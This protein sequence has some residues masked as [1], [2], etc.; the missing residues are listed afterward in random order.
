MSQRQIKGIV[1]KWKCP[2]FSGPETHKHHTVEW[3]DGLKVTRL[4]NWRGQVEICIE[5]KGRHNILRLGARV[6]KWEQ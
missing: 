6:R 3:G 4:T 1:Q 5:F 2:G